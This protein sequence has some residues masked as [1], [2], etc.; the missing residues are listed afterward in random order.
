M[1]SFGCILCELYCGLPIFPGE[2]EYDM[3]YY[4]MEYFGLPPKDLIENSINKLNYFTEDCKPLEKPNS[5]GK[6]RKPNKKSIE[7][8]LVNADEDFIDLIKNILKWKKEERFKPQDALKH[9]WII[10]NMTNEALK[11]HLKKIEEYSVDNEDKKNEIQGN[12]KQSVNNFSENGN[13]FKFMN[14][15]GTLSSLVIGDSKYSSLN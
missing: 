8:F 4:M 9:K 5:F 10:K 11:S 15:A 1:W 12:L 6:I 3:L 14:E 7:S 2:S 13:T